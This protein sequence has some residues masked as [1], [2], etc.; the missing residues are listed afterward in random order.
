VYTEDLSTNPGCFCLKIGCDD[1]L[2][3]LRKKKKKKKGKRERVYFKNSQGNK[4][5]KSSFVE[6]SNLWLTK[7]LI[8]WEF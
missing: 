8:W 2:F 5:I 3:S 1:Y 4:Q 7:K 6:A